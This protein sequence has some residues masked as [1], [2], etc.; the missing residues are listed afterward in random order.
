MATS[1]QILDML[2]KLEKG[3]GTTQRREQASR[4]KE[5]SQHQ[6]L[7]VQERVQ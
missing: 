1:G 2:G 3:Y 5:S 4:K 6:K 7:F